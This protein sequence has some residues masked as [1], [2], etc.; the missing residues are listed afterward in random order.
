MVSTVL[1]VLCLYFTGSRTGMLAFLAGLTVFY[2][3]MSEKKVLVAI[4]GTIT[5]A[6]IAVA[7]FPEASVFYFPRPDPAPGV[8]P[9]RD[10]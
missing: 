4:F 5:I 6:L 7:L 2:L 10:R 8:F 3:C 9:V 1:S